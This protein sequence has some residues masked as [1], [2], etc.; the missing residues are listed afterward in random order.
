[1]AA[2]GQVRRRRRQL[3]EVVVEVAGSRSIRGGD[4]HI[5]LLSTPSSFLRRGELIL[6]VVGW[7]CGR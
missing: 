7:G 1:M 2:V 3:G 6:V 4:Q 5:F